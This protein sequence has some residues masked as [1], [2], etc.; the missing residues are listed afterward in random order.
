MTAAAPARAL[1]ALAL[2]AACG[3]PTPPAPPPVPVEGPRAEVRLLAGSWAGEFVNLPAGRRGTIVFTLD[4]GRDTAHAWVVTE[5]AP[6][7]AGCTDAVSSAV[8]APADGRTV[9][10][11]GRVVVDAGSIAGWLESYR[12]FELGC[13]VD[14]WFE[15]RLVRDTLRGMFFAHPE[16]GDTVRRGTWWAARQR[17]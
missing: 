10:R 4:A 8:R 9:L 15:G 16:A 5:G 17:R 1:A 14:T 12:D 3:G 11:L 6:P 13:P 2:L 7:P